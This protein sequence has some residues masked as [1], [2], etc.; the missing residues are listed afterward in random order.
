M[1]A[2]L[3]EERPKM[4]RTRAVDHATDAAKPTQG[5]SLS[6]EKE[7]KHTVESLSFSPERI[8]DRA[9]T[10]TAL[11]SQILAQRDELHQLRDP[12]INE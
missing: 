1:G 10:T 2:S 5:R 3:S 11:L 6:D 7:N 8:T 12:G 9:S 4:K